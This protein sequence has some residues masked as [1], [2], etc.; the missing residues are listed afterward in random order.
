MNKYFY[1]LFLILS[2]AITSFSQRKTSEH[3]LKNIAG[4][5]IG[6]ESQ[7]PEQVKQ[8]AI[9][10]AKVNAL[11]KAGITESINS[12]S[13]YLRS[14]TENSYE[15][16]F[17][18]DILSNINGTVKNIDVVNAKMSV[19]PEGQIKYDVS[20]NCTVVKYKTKKDK[21]FEAWI[22]NIN[23][24]YKVGEGLSFTVKPTANCYIRAFIFCNESY[25]L[26]PND[27]EDSK[28]LTAHT[29]YTYPNPNIIDS[30]EMIIEDNSLDRETNRLVI[31]LLKEDIY[32]TDNVNYKDITDWIMSIPPDERMI[33]SFA[34]EVFRNR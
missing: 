6:G 17:T 25:V 10:E 5:A 15:E 12:Y 27:H 2:I 1:I 4:L 26:L 19:T 14:E 34:F 18:S 28:L 9:N 24:V 16:L 29:V 31:L 21:T 8:K 11:R 13:D 32:Y 30:Y 7:T 23:P 20:I 22:E 33:E 3:K